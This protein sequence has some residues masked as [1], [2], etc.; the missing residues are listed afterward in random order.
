MRYTLK[1]AS[2]AQTVAETLFVFGSI[3]FITFAIMSFSV[4]THTKFVATYAA[5]MAARS[6][7]VYGDQS[8]ADFH[9]EVSGSKLLSDLS[10]QE[11]LSVIRTAEDI[12]TCALPWMTV[13]AGDE[14]APFDESSRSKGQLPCLEGKRKYQKTNIDKQIAFYRFEDRS[15]GSQQNQNF[16]EPVAG[17]YIEAGRE[18]LRFAIMRLRYKNPMLT[19]LMGAFDNWV[20]SRAARGRTTID[21]ELERVYDGRVWFEV[22]VPALLNPSV[23]AGVKKAGSEKE[24]E[25]E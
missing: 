3:F 2:R 9:G 1:K 8:G 14:L 19:D 23:A 24:T 4:A 17:A 11:T 25:P 5:F 12:F 18:P 10:D 7:Q 13:P 15:L 6:Y 22:H 20:V 16:L 21:E